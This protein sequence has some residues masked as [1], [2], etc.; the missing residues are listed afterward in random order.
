MVRDNELVFEIGG[1][2]KG[3]RKISPEEKRA[4]IDLGFTED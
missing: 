4:I 3:S 1:A 2:V